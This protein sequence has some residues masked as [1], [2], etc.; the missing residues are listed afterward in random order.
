MPFMDG[1][2]ATVKIR[3]LYE[4]RGWRQPYIVAVTGH[5]EDKFIDIAEEAGMD[6]VVVKPASKK[7]IQKILLTVKRANTEE[8]NLLT[9]S[10][11]VGEN[12]NPFEVN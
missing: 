3:E 9:E 10:V 11:E 4:Q 8:Y 6:Q 2:Q 1:Y 12:E 7:E 5:G